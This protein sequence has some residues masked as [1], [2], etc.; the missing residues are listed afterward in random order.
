MPCCNTY[1]L[2]WFLLPWVW[3]ISSRLLQ[4]SAAAAP[5]LDEKH[6]LRATLPDLQ[7][8]IVP[9]GPPV[10]KQPLLSGRG[11]TPSGHHTWPRDRGGSSWL[12]QPQT[13]VDP[14]SRR[15]GLGREVAPL[16][17]LSH[18]PGGPKSCLFFIELII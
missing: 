15:P 1:H 16:A 6:V 10:P 17:T 7:R 4:Q 9:L 3:G 8:G 18:F 11:F 5:Y 13:W 14:L 2:T 12:P